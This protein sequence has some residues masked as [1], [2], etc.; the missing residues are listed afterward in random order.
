MPRS[1]NSC[2]HS[3]ES[4]FLGNLAIILGSFDQTWTSVPGDS[5]VRTCTKYL[6]REKNQRKRQWERFRKYEDVVGFLN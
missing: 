2:L 3:R 4:R 6:A 1:R 5:P